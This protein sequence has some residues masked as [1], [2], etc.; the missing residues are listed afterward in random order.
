MYCWG[1]WYWNDHSPQVCCRTALRNVNAQLYNFTR[2]YWT[3][4][5]AITF[6]FSKCLPGMLSACSYV[7]ADKFTACVQNVRIPNAR[8][9]RNGAG[10]ENK[11]CLLPR[12]TCCWRWSYC[13]SLGRY[14]G[15]SSCF[16]RTVLQ[17]PTHCARETIELLRRE[18][19]DFVSLEQ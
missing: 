19:S 10:D 18:M 11:R 2:S 5:G 16:S 14:Q 15:M 12:S 7:Y 17:P 13:Q 8:M 6:N 9:H 3:Q 4:Y 1:R